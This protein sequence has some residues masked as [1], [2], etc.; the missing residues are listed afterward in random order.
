MNR[1]YRISSPQIF[2][3]VLT[4]SKIFQK[5]HWLFDT[6]PGIVSGFR[7]EVRI[8]FDS[9]VALANNQFGHVV[10]I[11]RKLVAHPNFAL[12]GDGWSLAELEAQ[13]YVT[14][15]HDDD[16]FLSVA[17]TDG[18]ERPLRP[19]RVFRGNDVR[20]AELAVRLN[21]GYSALPEFLLNDHISKRETNVTF[22]GGWQV[23][24]TYLRIGSSGLP[25]IYLSEIHEALLSALASLLG[26]PWRSFGQTPNIVP[27]VSSK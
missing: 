2:E 21:I 5:H 20:A 17:A 27:M 7:P 13:T 23:S 22:L 26:S 15:T 12:D 8:D 1:K 14:M 25:N 11:D 4:K 6:H 16:A 24:P 19:S 3:T 10:T 9:N 18:L